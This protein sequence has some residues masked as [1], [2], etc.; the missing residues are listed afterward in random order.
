MYS[1]LRKFIIYFFLLLSISFI[2]D[3]ILSKYL[4]NSLYLSSWDLQVWNDI[5]SWNVSKD[6][7]IYWS[8]RAWRHIDCDIITKDTGESC[9]NVWID[10][11]NFWLQYLRHL[12][13]MKYNE[14]P[15]VILLSLDIF[16]LDRRDKLYHYEQFLPYIYDSDIRKFTKAY[17]T[18]HQLE[19]YFPLIRY[20]WEHT[21]K[22]EFL[23]IFLWKNT[24]WNKRINGFRWIWD[25][26]EWWIFNARDKLGF[27]NVT[28]NNDT[29]EVFREFIEY[30]KDQWIELIFVFSPQYIES[31]KY[32]K[33]WDEMMSIYEEYSS[34][35]NIPFL[36]YTGTWLSLE[37]EMF[38]DKLHLNK[39]W[40]AK[41]SQDLSRD[42]I[43]ITSK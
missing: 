5:Y 4:K 6:I 21:E 22:I 1:F 10:G 43:N 24:N 35:Y 17:N 11:H 15:K 26:W 13:V 30:T 14:K 29:I 38:Y 37:K 18:F 41:F 36:N 2:G 40:A 16:W 28:L 39:I 32:A 12:K 8:S 33:N 9:Y 42:I 3:L 27:Y 20:Y 19:Y 23:N 7:L 31:Y 25:T 34:K